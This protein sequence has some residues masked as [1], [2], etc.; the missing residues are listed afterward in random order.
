[1]KHSIY[2]SYPNIFNVEQQLFINELTGILSDHDFIPK[3]LGVTDC[4]ENNA[5]YALRKLILNCNGLIAVAFKR[6][7]IIN[8]LLKPGS[9]EEKMIEELWVTS[10]FC[11]IEPAMA[12]QTGLPIL[13]L[14]EKD[15]LSEGIMLNDISN[16]RILEFDL[17]HEEVSY[18]QTR[19][20]KSAFRV[21]CREVQQ[22]NQI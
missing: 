13:I 19:E 6:T 1:M 20:W 11:Q 16:I 3:T 15:V 12:Y 9:S 17:Q 8:G 2:L 21:W 4:V 7:K 5:L 22:L 10:P 14:K 18:L